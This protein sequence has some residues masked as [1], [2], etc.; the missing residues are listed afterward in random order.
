MKIL[1]ENMLIQ[2]S[3]VSFVVLLF[4]VVLLVNPFNVLSNV[5]SWDGAL[6]GTN[7]ETGSTEF[8]LLGF[9]LL[10]SGFLVL[11]GGLSFVIWHGWRTIT[12]QKA[13]L[14]KINA[15]LGQQVQE[16]NEQIQLID[17]IAQ[18]ITSTTDI[19]KVYERFADELRRLIDFQRANVR[20]LCDDPNFY[21]LKYIFGEERSGHPRGI[22]K[23][24]ANTQLESVIK[25][26]RTVNRHHIADKMEYP[27]DEE[28]LAIGLVSYITVPLRADGAVIGALTLRS[29]K[30][31]AFGSK[32][33]AILERLAGQIAPAIKN[34][35]LFEKANRAEERARKLSLAVETGPAGV[36]I[37]DAS[38]KIEYINPKFSRVTGYMEHEVIGQTPSILKSN[39]TSPQVYQDLWETI[40]EGKEWTGEL[41]NKK[42]S[43]EYYWSRDSIAPMFDSDHNVTHFVSIQED[44]T[45]RRVLE[46]TNLLKTRELEALFEIAGILI[47]PESFEHRCDAV[48]E[49]LARIGQADWVTL[50]VPEQD[51]LRL[52]ASSGSSNRNSPSRTWLSKQSVNSYRAFEEGTPIVVNNYAATADPL[53]EAVEKGMASMAHLPI[54]FGGEAIGLI[55]V[56]S[57][58]VNHFTEERV[59]L[60]TAVADGL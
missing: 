43:G 57:K 31:Y 20:L 45:D 56:V 16:G 19:Q 38:G 3:L 13:Q 4:A 37:T 7:L 46:E 28:Q 5:Q 32:E 18:I 33:Q 11:Y 2:F 52:I 53:P 60:L 55:S 36:M 44:I 49:E 29:D 47:W 24:L 25:T 9:A 21:V 22:I 15:E 23:P 26:G 41:L 30:P 17:E 10:F 34:A 58:Q 27:E 39:L 50:R 59:R 42:K 14:Q 54:K 8:N 48:L 51:S 12:R 6:R 40:G 35:D 1:R